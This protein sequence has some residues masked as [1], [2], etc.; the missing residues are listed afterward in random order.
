MK[1]RGRTL[2]QTL[3][4]YEKTIRPMHLEYVEPF[5]QRA[6]VILPRGGDSAAID[7]ICGLVRETIRKEA[8]TVGS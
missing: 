6:D 4:Q 8:K 3:N 7:F 2:E 5:K 1:E